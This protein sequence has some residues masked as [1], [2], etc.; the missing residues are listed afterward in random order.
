MSASCA[1]P[2]LIAGQQHYAALATSTMSLTLRTHY[3]LKHVPPAQERL[4]RLGYGHRTVRTLMVL[5]DR[6]DPPG[7]GRGAVQGRGGLRL[8]V[9][10]AVSHAEP[11][12]LERG[13]V[14][15]RR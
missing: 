8:A 15:R 6:D 14:R 10:V 2:A 4:Q 11:P 7:G 1:V 5:E 13:A 12:R 3:G 9:I